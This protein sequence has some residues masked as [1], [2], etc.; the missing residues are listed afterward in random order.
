MPEEMPFATG[1]EPSKED[2][3]TVKTT[4]LA[5]AAAIPNAHEKDYSALPHKNQK[6]VGICTAAAVTGAAEKFFGGS[7]RGSMEWL[8]KIGKVFI[9]GNTSEG[10]SAFTMLKA[11]QKYGIPSES[12]FPSNCDRSY[13]EFMS[14]LNIT[15]EMLDDAALHKIPGYAAVPMNPGDL[16]T[17]IYNSECG[18]IVRHTLGNEWWTDINGNYTNDP[19]KLQPLRKPSVAI[20]G[21]LVVQP[22]YEIVA[23][24]T[25]F[26][27]R[28]SW[29]DSWC[30]GGDAY[31]FFKDLIGYF[32]EAWTIIGQTP[33]VRDLRIGTTHEDVK[34]LQKWLNNHGYPV[35][36]TGAGSPGNE[37]LYFGLRTFN[38]LK[39]MQA[40]NGIPNTGYFG[41]ITRNFMNKHL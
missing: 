39:K 24:D 22:G 28:N 5:F 21:H 37:T 10:S 13:S 41:P 20:S 36:S 30:D 34:R 12:K 14:N 29:G 11:A 35:A 16:V 31:F 18:L 25:K 7:W 15:Q 4:D 38:A 3:R 6:K 8:Y 23:D 9:D 1:A 26:I 17:A 27:D 32:T 19:A 40:A 33:F 2:A